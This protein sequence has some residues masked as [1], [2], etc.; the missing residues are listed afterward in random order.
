MKRFFTSWGRLSCYLW[1]V[2]A[3]SCLWGT[4]ETAHATENAPTKNCATVGTNEQFHGPVGL[5]MYS[6]R[7]IAKDDM[8][9]AMK[10]ASQMG[11]R[12]VEASGSYGLTAEQYQALL[13]KYQLKAGAKNWGLGEFLTEE[14]LQKIIHEAKILGIKYVGIAWYPH[15][16]GVFTLQDAQEAATTFN[17]L[18]ERLN[19]DGLIFVYHNHGYEF[20]PWEGGKQGETLFDYMIQ[21]TNPK[22][23]TFEMDVLWTI[24]PGADPVAL[25][26]KYPDRFRLMHIKDLKKGVKGNLSGGTPVENDVALGSGQADYPAILKAAQEAG[27]EYYFIEDESPI[28][29]TQVP[30]SLKYLES[31]RWE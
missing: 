2:L 22:Y 26:K 9:A 3:V 6:F 8:D 13:E 5:Q 4:L 17:R 30:K 24:F 1:S 21:H 19:K 23:V 18:G 20:Y 29:E 31:V 27:V 12:Y 16:N 7:S 14:G 25:L 10:L 28:F 15:K 11:F